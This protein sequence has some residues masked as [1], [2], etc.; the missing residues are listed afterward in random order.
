MVYVETALSEQPLDVQAAVEAVSAREV[1]GIAAFIGTVRASASV[2][3]NE[4]KPVLRLDYEAHPALAEKRFQEIAASAADRWDLRAVLVVHRTG[5]CELGEPT[6]VVACGAP[7]RADA[8]EACRWVIDTLKT[9]A[10]IWKREVYA[11][12][13]SWVGADGH[14]APGG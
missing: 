2:A 1:G 12:G 10:P 3:G 11:D 8:L 14:E 13:S 4:S 6:V 9:T 7:H 5:T